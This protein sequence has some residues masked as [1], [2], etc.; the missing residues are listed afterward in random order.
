MT[1]FWRIAALVPGLLAAIPS[2]RRRRAPASANVLWYRSP[3]A[4]WNEALPIGNGR[5]GAMVFGGI[6]DERI[7]LNEDTVW[8][9]EKR[10][11]INPAGPA[12]IPEIRRLLFAGKPAEAEA[13]ADKA[14][15]AVPRA[16]AAVPDRSA[17]CSSLH[18]ASARRRVPPRAESRR[19]GRPRAA[20]APA[21]HAITREVVRVRGRSGDRRPARRRR[22]GSVACRRR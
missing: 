3:A 19:R 21:E 8:A 18:A 1:R 17:I 22:P 4:E 15:I 10:D 16:D 5:L 11:R 7:Q 6:A 13:L 2:H 12:A 14:V 20:T 9:G